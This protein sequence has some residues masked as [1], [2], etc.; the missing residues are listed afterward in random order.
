MTQEEKLKEAKRLYETANSDQKYV[1]E[2]LFPEL[3]KSEDERIRKAIHIYL[4]WLDGRKDYTPKGE[5]S[6][7]N[8]IAWLEKQGEQ[9]PAD[10]DEPKFNV[11][12][13]ITNGDYTWKIV[14]VK[15]LDYILQSQDGNIVDD[16]ISHV[17]EQFHSFTIQDAKEGDVLALSYESQNYIIIYR[18]LREKSFK[19][20]MSVFCDYNVE[21]DTFDDETDSFHVMNTGETIKPATKEQR[22]TLMK[23]MS[24]AGHTFDFEKKELK[25]LI[26]NGGDFDEK[27]C[28]QKHSID[29]NKMVDDYANNKERGN[30]EFGKPVPC[31]IRAYRQGLNDAIGKVVLKSSWSEEDESYLNTTIAY[32]KDAKEFKKTAENCINWLKSLKERIGG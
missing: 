16:T 17:D 4:D 3:K 25:L 18:G 13:W 29:I 11:G 5:Y 23:A 15:P 12:D 2:T 30:E 24:D 19:T 8:M 7:K 27:N 10:K 26:T 6:I 31:M 32:L 21:E 14:E 28:E 9:K 22:D 1:L 20:I